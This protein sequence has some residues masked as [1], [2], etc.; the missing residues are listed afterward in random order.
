MTVIPSRS[1]WRVL[2]MVLVLAGFVPTPASAQDGYPRERTHMIPGRPSIDIYV[3]GATSSRGPWKVTDGIPFIELMSILLPEGLG[4]VPDNVVQKATLD[5][6]RTDET[7]T[8][9]AQS[10]D[11]RAVLRGEAPPPTL[12]NLDTLVFENVVKPKRRITFRGVLNVITTSTSL[13]LLYLRLRSA[14]D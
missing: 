14:T 2:P 13:L 11:L 6:Y 8:H 4:N 3:L 5:V 10:V 7:G 9:L 12:K 1:F